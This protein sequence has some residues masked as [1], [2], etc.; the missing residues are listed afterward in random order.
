M[1]AF[2]VVLGAIAG[3]FLACAAVRFTAGRGLWGRSACIACG[4]RLAPEELVPVLSWLMLKGRC[5]ACAAPVSVFY[6]LVESATAVLTVSAGV[7]LEG[8]QLVAGIGLAWML[9][10]LAAIDICCHRLPDVLTMPLILVGLIAGGGPAPEAALGAVLGYAAFALLSM[11]YRHLS[12]VHGLGMGDAKLLA[13]AGSWAGP[14]ALPWVVL[15]AALASLGWI[16]ATS[17]GRGW[18]RNRRLAFGPFL[19]AALWLVWLGRTA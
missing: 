1:T 13:V 10:L 9:V 14:A 8:S 17:F 2:L 6:P 12:G 7:V 16:S 15:L 3:S 11:S 18:E 5:R 4:H 19:A